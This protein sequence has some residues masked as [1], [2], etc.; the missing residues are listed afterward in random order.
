LD[1]SLQAGKL[2][3]D[4]VAKEKANLQSEIKNRVQHKGGFGFGGKHGE[5]G[6][7]FKYVATV[8]GMNTQ[9]IQTQLQSG[10]SLVQISQAKGISETDFNQLLAKGKDRLTKM[11][12]QVGNQKPDTNADGETNDSASSSS[13]NTTVTETSGSATDTSATTT[14]S[15]TTTNDG[16]SN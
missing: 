14:K 5:R 10:K 9:D 8:L 13:T 1:K 7:E 2:T 11:V 6:G 16:S 12:E 15:T 3:Q 4:Q